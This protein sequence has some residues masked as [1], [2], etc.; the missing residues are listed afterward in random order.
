MKVIIVDIIENIMVVIMEV[1]MVD[2][3]VVITDDIINELN[4]HDA[5]HH[6]IAQ[7]QSAGFI[8]RGVGANPTVVHN[9]IYRLR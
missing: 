7:T 1:N 5:Q 2:V 6:H 4:C 9:V 3:M 8:A